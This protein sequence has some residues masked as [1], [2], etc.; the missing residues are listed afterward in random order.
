[1]HLRNVCLPCRNSKW[2]SHSPVLFSYLFQSLCPLRRTAFSF[3]E[4][5]GPCTRFRKYPLQFLQVKEVLL[6]FF[7]DNFVHSKISPGTTCSKNGYD[8]LSLRLWVGVWMGVFMITMC[9]FEISAWVAYIT[10]FTEE[11]FA[12][13]IATIYVYKVN[14]CFIP[15]L[16]AS[17]EKM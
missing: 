7:K 3:V 10:R 1:M 12:L 2:P 4:R 9:A 5:H 14:N 6:F 17:H 16:V 11:N 15:L 13:L 8:Y